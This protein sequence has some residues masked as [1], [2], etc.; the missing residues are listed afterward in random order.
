MVLSQAS[1]DTPSAHL[2]LTHGETL[3]WPWC[4]TASLLETLTLPRGF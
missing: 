1:P 3:L 4:L 2:S